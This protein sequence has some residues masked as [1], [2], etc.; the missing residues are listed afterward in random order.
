MLDDYAEYVETRPLSTDYIERAHREIPVIIDILKKEM[1]ADGRE[2]ACIDASIIV[3]HRASCLDTP[4][5]VR[6][7]IVLLNK[8]PAP[9]VD[10]KAEA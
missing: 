9:V 4:Q 7:H 6:T 3:R 5:I 1:V 2:G 10:A 8:R